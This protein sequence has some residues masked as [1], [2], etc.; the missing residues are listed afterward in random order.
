MLIRGE[1]HP[2][3]IILGESSVASFVS[4][5]FWPYSMAVAVTAQY[6]GKKFWRADR[7]IHFTLVSGGIEQTN[8]KVKG[9]GYYIR[10]S[11]MGISSAAKSIKRI[12]NR[13]AKGGHDNP[14]GRCSQAFF[15][16]V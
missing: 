12:E 15:G 7:D 5:P 11:Y 13:V 6:M 2:F 16:A 8:L 3:C 10:L 1:D 4:I 9:A 14:L